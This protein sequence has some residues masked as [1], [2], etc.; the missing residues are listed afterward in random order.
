MSFFQKISQGI[1][2]TKKS[3]FTNVFRLFKSGKID[4]DTLEELE[5][6]LIGGDLGYKTSQYILSELKKRSSASGSTAG[7][8]LLNVLK[9]IL[10]E[11]LSIEIKDES[12]SRPKIVLVVGVNGV[13]KTTTI[14][15]LANLKQGENQSV[16][17]VAGDTFRAAAVDQLQIWADRNKQEIVRL[18]EGADPSA[19]VFDGV[20]A[21]IARKKDICLIDTAG[22][23]HN[24]DHLMEQLAKMVKVIKKLIPDAPHEVILVL[25]A[26]MGQ[27]AVQQ[28]R[29]FNELLKIDS[30]ILTKLDGTAK[31]GVIFSIYHDLHIPVK[32]VGTGEG[33]DDLNPFDASVFIDA[34]FEKEVEEIG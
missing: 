9:T 22:R 6:I 31:G 24:K 26:T 19:V 33:I 8:N 13:G 32:Y 1:S 21:A 12:Q 10:A 2:R 15:K 27:N 14:G 20:Q 29:V 17:L 34:L 16:I 23:L 3:V 18:K 28:A 30:I 11:L 4:D 25:D 7:D 5:E